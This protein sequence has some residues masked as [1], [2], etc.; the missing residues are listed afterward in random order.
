[1]FEPTWYASSWRPRIPGSPGLSD[2]GPKRGRQI[3]ETG[4]VAFGEFETKCIEC[5]ALQPAGE[6]NVLGS[7][8]APSLTNY[9][10]EQ[11]LREFLANPSHEKYYGTNNAMPAF[12]ERLSEKEFDLLVKW[13]LGEE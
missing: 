8:G 6:E 2:A 5:H 3:F 10:G 1:M 11:W 13:M 9:M 4:K 12:G 7:E